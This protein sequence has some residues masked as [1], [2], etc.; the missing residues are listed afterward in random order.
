MT[1]LID[2]TRKVQQQNDT[3]SL[4][5]VLDLFEPKIRVSLRQTAVQEQDDLYQELKIIAMEIIR[6]YDFNKTY[7]FWEY[8]DR[9][10]E[11]ALPELS[12]AEIT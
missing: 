4:N 6:K 9:L 3:D 1:R 12:E 2:L 11:Q 7:G 8:T 5:R 10:K